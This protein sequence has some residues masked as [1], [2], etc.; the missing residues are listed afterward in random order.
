MTDPTL[1]LDGAS[2]PLVQ[3]G[4][5]WRVALRRS[6]VHVRDEAELDLLAHPHPA[7]MPCRV[8]CE[9]DAVTLHLEPVPGA[10]G[11]DELVRRPRSEVLRALINVGDC[12]ELVDRGYGV[13]LQPANLQFDRNLRPVLAY[14]GVAG[15]MPPRETGPDHLLRQHRALVIC[16]FDSSASFEQLVDGALETRR[17]SGLERAALAAA[18]SEELVGHLVGLYEETT[19]RQESR[20]VRVDRHRH[21]ALKHATIWLGVLALG[22]GA[23]AVYDTFVRAPFQERMLS[24]DTH[25]VQRDY[26]GVIETLLPVPEERLPLTQRYELAASYLRGASLTDEQKSAIENTLA[27]SAEPAV[28]TYWVQIG[29]GDLDDALDTAKGL[30][31]VDLILYALTL[32]QEQVAADPGLSGSDRETK[33]EELQ[34]A[35]DRYLEQ[36]TAALDASGTDAAATAEPSADATAED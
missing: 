36:R 18:S 19:A 28:L 25:F 14:R 31:D 15:A 22:C 10:I 33:L 5:E 26:D 6:A 32:Q 34:T 16:A 29:R 9:E 1:T 13:L 21:L 20:T 12:R 23:L 2:Y 30:D 35:Y 24:A 27:I 11:W 3:S 7:L 17:T 8:T 4:Q